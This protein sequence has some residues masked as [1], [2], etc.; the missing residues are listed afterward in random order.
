MRSIYPQ[1]QLLSFLRDADRKVHHQVG[2]APEGVE[3]GDKQRRDLEF[4]LGNAVHDCS[5]GFLGEPGR[6]GALHLTDLN[7]GKVIDRVAEF[8]C[9]VDGKY[10]PVGACV[11][12]AGDHYLLVGFKPDQREQ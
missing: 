5:A 2:A 12:E 7:R 1:G 4:D 9:I 6:R 10:G 8:L 11:D 3:A